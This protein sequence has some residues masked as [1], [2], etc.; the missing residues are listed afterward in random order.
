MGGLGGA[1]YCSSSES[2]ICCWN[3]GDCSGDEDIDTIEMSPA[4]KVRFRFG[5]VSCADRTACVEGG[6]CSDSD[7]V[8]QEWSRLWRCSREVIAG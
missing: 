2:R 6:K 1:K 3:G 8:L 7:M 5:G 4:A